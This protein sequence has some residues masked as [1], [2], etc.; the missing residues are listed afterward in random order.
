MNHLGSTNYVVNTW[1]AHCIERILSMKNPATTIPMFAGPEISAFSGGILTRLFDLIQQGKTPDKLA[2]NDY[3][4]KCVLR[5]VVCSRGDLLPHV[6]LILERLTFIIREISKN[7]SNPKFNHFAFETLSAVVKYICVAQPSLVANFETALFGPFQEILAHDVVEFTP[8]VFQVL[9]QLLALHGTDGIP[10]VYLTLL[11]PLLQPAPWENYANIPALVNFLSS[12]LQKNSK[13]IIQSG[14]FQA[15]LGIFQ[16]L[17]ASRV[18]DHHGLNFL[19][20][21]FEYVPTDALSPYTKN[22]F[23]L[24]LTRI[25]QSKTPKFTKHFLDFL[26]YVILLEKPG[27][28]VDEIIAVIESVQGGYVDMIYDI[29]GLTS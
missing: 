10:Q 29:L 7:P 20:Q 11:M 25:F 24:L 13:T 8:Y 26:S 5:V 19:K 23:V 6:T 1:A 17:V 9:S 2:E 22:L 14:H 12:F 3:L 4:M 21:V 28:G 15:F 27:F 16:K 18:N